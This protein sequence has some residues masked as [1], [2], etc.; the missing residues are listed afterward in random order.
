MLYYS[1]ENNCF[2]HSG[3]EVE[4]LPSDIIEIDDDYHQSLFSS[5]LGIMPDE[6]GFPINVPVEQA[7]IDDLRACMILSAAEARLR[8]AEKGLLLRVLEVINQLQDDNA[9]KI[10]WEYSITLH[11]TDPVL[12]D[13]CKQTM[14]MTDAQIDELFT[15]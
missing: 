8:L 13:F 3:R 4:T 10:K 9:L 14:G 1:A 15:S 5:G 11:R 2:Y 12:V 7:T 6:N